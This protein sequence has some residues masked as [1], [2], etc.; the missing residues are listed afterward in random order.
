MA[1]SDHVAD[2]KRKMVSACFLASLFRK[3]CAAFISRPRFQI[4]M[5]SYIIFV[6]IV[7]TCGCYVV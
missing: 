1:Q 6:V 2:F 5:H 7:Y 3:R 4:H